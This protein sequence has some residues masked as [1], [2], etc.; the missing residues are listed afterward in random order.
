MIKFNLA[1]TLAMD[2]HEGQIRKGPANKLGVPVS[3]ISHPVAVDSPRFKGAEHRHIRGES[4]R[5]NRWQHHWRVW[6]ARRGIDWTEGVLRW[7]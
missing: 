5:C 1:L 6:Q 3:Y 4:S 7:G 2:A